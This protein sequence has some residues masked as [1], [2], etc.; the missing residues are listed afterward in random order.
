MVPTAILTLVPK[1]PACIALY[2]AISFSA[3]AWLRT[4]AIAMCVLWLGWL[5]GRY[6]RGRILM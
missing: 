2:L 1:C 4:G 6:L 5:A 3:A